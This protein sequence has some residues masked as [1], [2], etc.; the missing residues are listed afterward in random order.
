MIDA[1]LH[2]DRALLLFIN[3]LSHPI[4]DYLMWTFSSKWF[5]M[6]LIFLISMA[7]LR[8]YPLRQVLAFIGIAILSI[9]AIDLLSTY[10]FK[11]GF[12]RLRPSHVQGLREQLHF[13]RMA[14]GSF[15]QGGQFG[16]VSAHAANLVGILVLLWPYFG[17]QKWMRSLVTILVV[18]ISVSRVYLGVH[19][20]SDIIAGAAFGALFAYA[21][22]RLLIRPYLFN[23]VA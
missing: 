9:A 8:N 1:I 21:V 2:I 23:P 11:E 15:Y 20:P 17:T 19:Y 7:L 14:D 4:L 10:A 12:E 22:R 16:F 3:G 13:H 18:L 5:N 6:P